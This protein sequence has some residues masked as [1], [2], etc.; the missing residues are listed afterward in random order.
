MRHSP[1]T[2]PPAPPRSRFAFAC[3]LREGWLTVALALEVLA[4]AWI[5]TRLRVPALRIVALALVAAVIVRLV[6][7]PAVL[8]YEGS[9]G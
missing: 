8:S 4:L 6:L 9:A 2:L 7:N 5:W 3:L 1:S